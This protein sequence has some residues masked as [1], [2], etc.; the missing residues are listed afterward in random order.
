LAS[1]SEG[2]LSK[3][4]PVEFEEEDALFKSVEGLG[5]PPGDGPGG[6]GVVVLVED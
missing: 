1:S 6:A 2:R 3:D 5:G 4:G